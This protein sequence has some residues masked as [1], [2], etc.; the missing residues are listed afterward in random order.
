MIYY[1]INSFLNIF[2]IFLKL[3]W[4]FWLFLI[5]VPLF[6]STFL[7]WRQERFRYGKSFNMI[8]LEIKIPREIK[9]NPKAMEQILVALHSLRNA[10]GTFREKW[11]DGEITVWFSLELISIGGN[12][13]FF[14]RCQESKKSLVESAFYSY[15]P[16]IELI[17]VD[18]Y[19]LNLPQNMIEVEDRGM[20][21]WG[22]EM[23]L[24]KEEAYP[25]KTYSDFESSEET[26]QY[27]PISSFLEFFG[28]IQKEEFL[29]LQFILAPAAPDWNKKYE[30]LVEDLKKNK[31]SNSNSPD[32]NAP[33]SYNRTPKEIDVL[34]KVEENLSKLA[35][36]TLIRFIYL[37]PKPIFNNAYARIGLNS[38]FNQYSSI[39]LNSFK[40]NK[41]V[42]TGAKI[43]DPPYIFPQ[44]RSWYRKAVFLNDYIQRNCPPETFMGKLITSYIFRLNFGSKRFLM[45]TQCLATLFHPPTSLVLLNETHIE[46]IQSRKVGPPPNLAIFGEEKDI[47]KFYE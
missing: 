26:K 40:A 10:P 36:N 5:L 12:I 32:Q 18:D 22:T 4:W 35:F 23:F 17:E 42:T 25:I 28:K 11:I 41:E 33:Q 3:S 38:S 20:D 8:V 37:S 27:D 43:W 24:A 6:K 13:K 2:F 31:S 44:K 39:E 7:H 15:Y 21:L 29:G 30:K 14:I 19:V 16:E 47:E 46:K 45:T 34:K 9:Q 1:V